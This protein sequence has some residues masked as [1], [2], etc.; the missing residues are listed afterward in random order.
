M[1]ANERLERGIESTRTSAKKVKRRISTRTERMR[2]VMKTRE[3]VD[4]ETGLIV[5]EHTILHIFR[6]TVARVHPHHQT[7]A[8][9]ETRCPRVPPFSCREVDYRRRV[10]GLEGSE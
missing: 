10:R 9:P 4:E 1:S 3:G 5:G 6:F 7:M 8:R 2:D